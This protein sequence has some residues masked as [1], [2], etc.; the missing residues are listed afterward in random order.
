MMFR[1]QHANDVLD[2]APAPPRA[3][4]LF[5]R[6]TW[7]TFVLAV[8][9]LALVWSWRFANQ[10]HYVWLQRQLFTY[11]VPEGPMRVG[12]NAH[13]ENATIWPQASRIIPS[14][15]DASGLYP[16]FIHRRTAPNG[17]TRLMVVE[18]FALPGGFTT[19]L[20]L[21]AAAYAPATLRPGSRL[22]F[23]RS[24][25]LRHGPIR[26]HGG[27]VDPGDDSHFTIAYDTV[28]GDGTIDGWLMNDGS[29]KLEVRDGPLR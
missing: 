13:V 12:S 17:V 5:R 28:R 20:L 27:T 18:E 22:Q 25:A 1:T 23:G 8:G 19:D 15:D 10:L 29:V 9:T 24:M 3:H 26:L 7:W 16:I 11:N 6:I 21:N 14:W 4:R 2:Y